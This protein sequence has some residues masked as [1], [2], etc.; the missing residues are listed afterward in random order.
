MV[1]L[2][3]RETA[4]YTT[5]YSTC[6]A[7]IYDMLEDMTDLSA[8]R[9]LEVKVAEFLL[10]CRHHSSTYPVFSVVLKVCV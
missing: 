2:K 4:S 6:K 10:Q 3:H 8:N 1:S 9:V 5:S 7:E